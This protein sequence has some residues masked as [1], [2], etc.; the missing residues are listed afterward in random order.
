MGHEIAHVLSDYDSTGF[1]L[2]QSLRQHLL[3]RPK[4]EPRELTQA[5][6]AGSQGTKYPH[7]PLTLEEH[8]DRDRR[9]SYPMLEIRAFA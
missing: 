2:T 3:G 8:G 6:G 7:S 9:V 4:N 1:Q 5:D